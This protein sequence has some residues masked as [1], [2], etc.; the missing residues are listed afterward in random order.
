MVRSGCG[1][2]ASCT[3]SSRASGNKSMTCLRQQAAQ[4]FVV[5]DDAL[6]D[7]FLLDRAPGA[8][9]SSRSRPPSVG[10]HNAVMGLRLTSTSVPRLSPG[11]PWNDSQFSPLRSR[12]LRARE[13]LYS[14]AGLP[15][16][17]SWIRLL[18]QLEVVVGRLPLISGFVV[19]VIRIRP[20]AAWP[21]AESCPYAWPEKR[22]RARRRSERP[23]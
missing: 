4:G 16:L 11:I 7:L 9:T 15:V 22:A 6:A 3:G 5:E 19:D 18:A 12:L 1:G 20:E 23:A 14:C 10:V 8:P 13:R 21:A 2:S 17:L